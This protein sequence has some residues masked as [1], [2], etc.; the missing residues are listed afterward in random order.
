MADEDILEEKSKEF[1]PIITDSKNAARV[2]EENG[3]LY[4]GEMKLSKIVF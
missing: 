1:E 3:I 2:L 4:E